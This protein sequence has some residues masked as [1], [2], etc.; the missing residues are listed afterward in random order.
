MKHFCLSS[1]K[2][3]LSSYSLQGQ[4]PFLFVGTTESINNA[5]IL[6]EYNLDHLRVSTLKL[7]SGYSKIMFTLKL[8]GRDFTIM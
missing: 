8:K 6:L 2:I 4:V 7:T 1:V 5:K 3:S